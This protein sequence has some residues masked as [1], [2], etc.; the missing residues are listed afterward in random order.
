[1]KQSRRPFPFD[2]ALVD[3]SWKLA[4]IWLNFVEI[5]DILSIS[6]PTE[7]DYKSF[8]AIDNLWLGEVSEVMRY[9][10]LSGNN[11]K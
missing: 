9:P 7:W 10:R 4:G 11:T 5:R 1:M 8:L 6:I 3:L 2:S